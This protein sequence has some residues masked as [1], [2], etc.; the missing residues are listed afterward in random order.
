MLG[1]NEDSSLPE[2]STAP[3]ESYLTETSEV[4]SNQVFAPQETPPAPEIASMDA[5][6][7]LLE[8]RPESTVSVPPQQLMG[9]LDATGA[10]TIEYPTGSGV[11]WTRNSPTE[12]WHHR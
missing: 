4:A 3:N 1:L 7:D 11:S 8:S 6:A 2:S 5:F 12:P 10:E 9:M